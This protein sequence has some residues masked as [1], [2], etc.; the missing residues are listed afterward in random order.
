MLNVFCPRCLAEETQR[1]DL[2]DGN[3]ITCTG[4]EETYTVEDVR[5]LVDGWA[6]LL[7]WLEAHPARKED[8]AV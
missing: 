6:K 1:L 8:A 4:C 7:P 2:D 5:L 3:T